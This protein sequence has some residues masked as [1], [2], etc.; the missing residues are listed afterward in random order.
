MSLIDLL[1]I[2][3]ATTSVL[4]ENTDGNDKI[5]NLTYADVCATSTN[6][7][8]THCSITSVLDLFYDPTLLDTTNSTTFLSNIRQSIS[9]LTDEE[10]LSRLFPESGTYSS[11]T[12]RPMLQ[13]DIMSVGDEGQLRAYKVK[14]ELELN[15][16]VVKVGF[17]HICI[18]I[19]IHK[20][21][22]NMFAFIYSY[23]QMLKFT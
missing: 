10:I 7:N 14:L 13:R 20:F 9:K 3:S 21:I 6:G 23:I 19:H 2:S 11:W 12:G 18:Y 16:E 4:I 8:V 1:E 5:S 17:T 22:M 15:E